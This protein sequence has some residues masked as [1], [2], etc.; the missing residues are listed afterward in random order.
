MV[1]KIVIGL[2]C[3]QYD[4]FFFS[5]TPISNGHICIQY[6]ELVDTDGQGGF[7]TDGQGGFA[8]PP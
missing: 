1:F 2:D 8:E 5:C 6:D 7:D 3:H 4:N